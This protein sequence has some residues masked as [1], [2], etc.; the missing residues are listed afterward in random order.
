M[1]AC[2]RTHMH[3]YTHTNTHT[4]TH[5]YT[6]IHMHTYT[7]TY[8]HTYT[9]THTNTHAR[10]HTRALQVRYLDHMEAKE[11]RHEARLQSS[12]LANGVESKAQPG[13]EATTDDVATVYERCLVPCASYPGACVHA[14]VCVWPPCTSAAWCRAPAIQVR[15]CMRV[16]ACAR[17]CVATV[18]ERCLVPCA[19]YPGA[20]VHA[21]MR[22]CVCV[23]TVYERC[24]VPCASCPG[25]SP[26]ANNSD[27]SCSCPHLQLPAL[28]AAIHHPPWPSLALP[29]PSLHHPPFNAPAPPAPPYLALPGHPPPSLQ[30]ATQGPPLIAPCPP[31]ILQLTSSAPNVRC[32]PPLTLPL[33]APRSPSYPCRVLGSSPYPAEDRILGSP[34]TLISR[35]SLCSLFICLQSTGSAT[36]TGLSGRGARRQ[37][38][39]PWHGR[40]PPSAGSAPRRTS[41]PH[42]MR[43]GM[44]RCVCARVRVCV[45]VCVCVCVCVYACRHLLLAAPRGAPHGRTV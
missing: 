32:L 29:L 39:G 7:Q 41:W 26:H 3:T 22:V 14:C 43:S 27:P 35:Q 11:G 30:A 16:C 4:H 19:S 2:A 44:G 34:R 37:R 18:Y 13:T 1:R 38:L 17:V 28:G 21:C 42:G 12:K 24:L 25:A 8:T 23:A 20:C 40:P 15:A 6:H 36:C 5:T 33:T 45:H 31:P 9:R 10:T